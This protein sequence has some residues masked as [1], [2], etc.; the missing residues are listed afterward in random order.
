MY[1]YAVTKICKI[2]DGDT[3]DLL[4]DLG[5]SIHIKE[6]VRV[7]GIDAP[8]SFTSDLNEKKFGI[9]AK[10][11]LENWLNAQ[12]ALTIKTYKDDKYGRTLGKIYGDS[13]VCVNDLMVEQGYAWVYDGKSKSKD[14]DVLIEKRKIK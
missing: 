1:E 2:V 7:H 5:F 13:G 4:I 12:T 10:E 3:V 6:R 9:E 8:E 11:F 14:F